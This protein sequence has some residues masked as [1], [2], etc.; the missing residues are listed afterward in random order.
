V[1]TYRD[2]ATPGMTMDLLAGARMLDVRQKLSW[3]LVGNGESMP[4]SSRS[5]SSEASLKNWDA[6]IG[7]KGRTAVGESGKLFVP[8]YADVGTGNSDLTWQAMAGV[9]YSFGWGDVV[10]AWR[11]LDYKMKP[12]KSIEDLTFSGPTIAAVFHW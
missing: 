1:G 6:I 4:V 12:G 2:L 8:Y 10:A 11:Y 5:G 7:L 9:G 3:S